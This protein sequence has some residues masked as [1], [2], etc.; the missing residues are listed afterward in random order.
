MG[1]SRLVSR[2]STVVFC[3]SFATVLASVAKASTVA[4]VAKNMVAIAKATTTL[5]A[6]SLLDIKSPHFN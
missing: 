4:V 5:K 2:V 3:E 1:R 6:V